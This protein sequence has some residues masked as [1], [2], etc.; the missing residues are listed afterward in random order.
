[1]F[2]NITTKY[3]WRRRGPVVNTETYTQA[4]PI[5][6]FTDRQTDLGAQKESTPAKQISKIRTRKNDGVQQVSQ[7]TCQVAKA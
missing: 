6:G 7:H 2:L 5:L 3:Y 1:M 4:G